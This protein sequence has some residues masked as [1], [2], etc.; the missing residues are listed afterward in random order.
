MIIKGND[1]VL[2]IDGKDTYHATSHQCNLDANFEEYETKDSDGK[3]NVL[4]G[5]SGTAT[6]DG[7][8]NIGGTGN[9]VTPTDAMDTPALIDA[10]NAGAKVALTLKIGTKLYEADAWITNVSLT[11][12]VAANSTYSVSL[13]FNSLKPKAS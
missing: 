8:V 7:L 13:K 5:H 3:Q 4:I 1:L 2:Q 6:A 12:A 9:D 10:F 11:G